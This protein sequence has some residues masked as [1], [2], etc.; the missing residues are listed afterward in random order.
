MPRSY[1]FDE[2]VKL[3]YA[4]VMFRLIF[5]KIELDTLSLVHLSKSALMSQYPSFEELPDWRLVY[6]TIEQFLT[7]KNC[8]CTCSICLKIEHSI[9]TYIFYIL[10]KYEK[11]QLNDNIFVTLSGNSSFSLEANFH[12]SAKHPKTSSFTLKTSTCIITY[13]NLRQFY[14]RHSERNRKI[15]LNSVKSIK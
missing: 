11:K 3:L 13:L 10:L 15:S 1:P 5:H 8:I 9:F 7:V 12:I 4:T 6:S 2:I 14:A